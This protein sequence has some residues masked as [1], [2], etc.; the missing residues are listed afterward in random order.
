MPVMG[1]GQDM[2]HQK[3]QVGSEYV[4][5][6]FVLQSIPG[7]WK[8]ISQLVCDECSETSAFVDVCGCGCRCW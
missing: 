7:G 6:Y 3:D 5:A 8:I 4:M 2:K 1:S